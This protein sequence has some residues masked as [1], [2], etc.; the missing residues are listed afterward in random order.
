MYKR[1]VPVLF[2]LMSCGGATSEV[3]DQVPNV[4]E[5]CRHVF[6]DKLDADWIAMRGQKPD[7]KTRLRIFKDGDDY[8]GYFI[9]GFFQRIVLKGETRDGDVRFTEVPTGEKA[10]LFEKGKVK[11]I[12]V[13]VTPKLKDC[14]L[15]TVVGTVNKKGKEAISPIGFDLMAFPKLEVTFTFEPSDRTLFVGAAAKN[16]AVADKQI[17]ANGQASPE[18]E[19]GT[20]PVGMFS[21]AED[22]GPESCTYDMDL[23]F[24]DQSVPEL[25]AVA[26]GEVKDGFRHWYVDWEAPYS[27]NHHFEMYRYK[28]CDGKRERIDIAALEAVLH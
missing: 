27:G 22:D 23:Y 16:R 26:A 7:P 10:K 5:Q 28:T 14:A 18:H 6:M 13:Y 21:K 12:R 24:D 25:A 15:K 20:I 4:P 2:V 1:V 11:L 3:A 19:F 9:N 8:G 17:A